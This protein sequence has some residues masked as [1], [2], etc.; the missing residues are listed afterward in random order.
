MRDKSL[1]GVSD[2]RDES[3][4]DGMRIVVELKRGEVAEVVLNNLYKQTPLQT[5]FGMIMLAIVGGRPRVLSL[6]DFV[7]RSSSSVTRWSSGAP[8]SSCGRRRRAHTCSRG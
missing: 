4:R 6:L 8:R 7:E 3:D 2:L 5:T 1:E